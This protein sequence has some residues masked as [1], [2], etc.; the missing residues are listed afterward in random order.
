MNCA[1]RRMITR[2]PLISSAGLRFLLM[3][4]VSA[5][6]FCAGFRMR[7]SG[8]CLALSTP[9]ALRLPVARKAKP[10]GGRGDFFSSRFG[11]VMLTYHTDRFS[12][13]EETVY[14]GPRLGMPDVRLTF[15]DQKLRDTVVAALPGRRLVDLLG[16]NSGNFFAARSTRI[17]RAAIMTYLGSA[18]LRLELNVEWHSA[19][20]ALV[21]MG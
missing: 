11:K 10:H 14:D 8:E 5:K 2:D 17:S 19:G 1:A 20:R 16:T 15:W 6:E 7:A 9:S 21:R 3:A 18:A 13:V 12:Y 4:N